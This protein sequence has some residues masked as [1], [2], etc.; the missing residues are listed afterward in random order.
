MR[1]SYCHSSWYTYLPLHS[2]Q[3]ASESLQH[4]QSSLQQCHIQPVLAQEMP[5]QKQNW[6]LILVELLEANILW[7]LNIHLLKLQSMQ[8]RGQFHLHSVT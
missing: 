5:F 4:T 6:Y 2:E 1:K 3:L 7:C 8:E